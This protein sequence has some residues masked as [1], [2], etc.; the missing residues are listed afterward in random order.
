M[1]PIKRAMV[2]LA[3]GFLAYVDRSS[4]EEV[5]DVS[6][7]EPA[8]HGAIIPRSM[9]EKV[10]PWENL[11]TWDMAEEVWKTVEIVGR[12]VFV[13]NMGRLKLRSRGG[14]FVILKSKINASSMSHQIYP[15]K[16][17]SENKPTQLLT[18]RLVLLTFLGEAQWAEKFP[19]IIERSTQLIT[20]KNG[21][22]RDCRLTNLAWISKAEAEK[23]YRRTLSNDKYLAKDAKETPVEIEPVEP[24]VQ[25]EL[26]A[27]SMDPN[28]WRD[29]PHFVGFYQVTAAG[30]VRSLDRYIHRYG[31]TRITPENTPRYLTAEKINEDLKKHYR[32][33]R[34]VTLKPMRQAGELAVVLC[35]DGLS[36]PIPV[37][38]LL[39]ETFHP[40]IKE[41]YKYE[42]IDGNLSNCTLANLRLLQEV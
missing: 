15:L 37:A 24:I 27:T 6:R 36:V 26:I 3:R 9:I 5:Q 16:A 31:K 18:S 41:S 20:Y 38:R 19:N 35:R 2:S 39:I 40:Q 30:E 12:E 14:N 10:N 33:V 29:V 25:P 32:F 11:D 22:F 4:N 23:I 8:I 21:D 28:D 17:G 13:S 1:N 42:Y 7:H 34:G